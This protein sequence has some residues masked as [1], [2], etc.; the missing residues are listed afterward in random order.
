LEQR[1][2]D[3]SSNSSLGPGEYLSQNILP[4]FQVK[5]GKLGD[6]AFMAPERVT[7]DNQVKHDV[8]GPDTYQTV[9]NKLPQEKGTKRPF[10]KNQI[11]FGKDDNGVPGAGSYP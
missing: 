5:R 10:G 7:L 1:F 2:R 3:K 8:P 4:K 11:R 9:D 6:P